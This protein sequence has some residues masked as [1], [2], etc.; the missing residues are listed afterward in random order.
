M[1]RWY[2]GILISLILIGAAF[3]AYASEPIRIVVNGIEITSDVPPQTINGRIMVPV[4]FI[5]EALGLEVR[6]DEEYKAVIM[7]TPS[8]HDPLIPLQGWNIDNPLPP[9]KSL[10]VPEGIKISVVNFLDGDK[11]W[12]ILNNNDE[13]TFSAIPDY[14]NKYVLVTV[15]AKNVSYKREV[16]WVNDQCFSLVSPSGKKYRPG[17]RVIVLQD[18]GDLKYLTGK[19]LKYG[20]EIT[21]TIYFYVP[22]FEEDFTL[23]WSKGSVQENSRFFKL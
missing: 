11:A 22:E 4:R 18:E 17:D 16:V 5:A 6:W 2:I 3:V 7:S 15:R 9:G 23:I 1:K 13:S 14:R 20:D 8:D 19:F 12:K 21:A 10:V